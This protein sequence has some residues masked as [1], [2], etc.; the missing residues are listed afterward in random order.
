MDEETSLETYLKWLDWEHENDLWFEIDG[1]AAGQLAM[2]IRSLMN[3]NERLKTEVRATSS[4]DRQ[5]QKLADEQKARIEALEAAL[6]E[7]AC[8]QSVSPCTCVNERECSYGIARAALA[9]EKKDD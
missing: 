1:N 6:R 3:E 7:I 8:D 5:M 2:H 9:G 4:Y